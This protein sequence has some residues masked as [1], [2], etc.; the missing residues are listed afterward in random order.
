[1]DIDRRR[2]AHAVHSLRT[3]QGILSRLVLAVLGAFDLEV[4]RGDARGSAQ[5]KAN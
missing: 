2:A 3:F 5:G 4:L 1:M